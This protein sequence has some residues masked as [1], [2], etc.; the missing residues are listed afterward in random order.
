M[1]T[2]RKCGPL[3]YFLLIAEQQYYKVYEPMMHSQFPL[4]IVH[5]LYCNSSC[6]VW[7]YIVVRT[8]NWPGSYLYTVALPTEYLLEH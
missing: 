7:L 8:H 2:S 1:L 3:N 4:L 5:Y 6:A